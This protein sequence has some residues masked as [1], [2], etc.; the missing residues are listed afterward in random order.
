MP[1]HCKRP[2][3]AIYTTGGKANSLRH[4][5]WKLKVCRELKDLGQEYITEAVRN[6]PDPVTG[7]ERRVDVVCLDDGTEYEIETDK[8]RAE[9]FKG[10]KGVIVIK[11][12]E[13]NEEL[14]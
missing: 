5:F 13:I 6:E 2:R 9:R 3:N 1:T 4:E 14:I 12:W 7:K 10:E 8:K 11:L